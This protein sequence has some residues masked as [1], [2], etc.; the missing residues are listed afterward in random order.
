MG[1]DGFSVDDEKSGRYRGFYGALKG[2]IW[3]S[4]W[5][6]F[7]KWGFLWALISDEG[8]R[9]VLRAFFWAF[10]YSP[11]FESLISFLSKEGINPGSSGKSATDFSWCNGPEPF[12]RSMEKAVYF[13]GPLPFQQVQPCPVDVHKCIDRSC[14]S[15]VRPAPGIHEQLF[16]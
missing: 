16:P 7:A 2:I 3:G 10:L 4:I 13:S 12:V 15:R 6:Y 1:P 14:I 9:T 5:A 11:R 8:N